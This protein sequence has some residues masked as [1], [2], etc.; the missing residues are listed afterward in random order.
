MQLHKYSVSALL[1]TAGLLL[2]GC[3]S[4]LNIQP[5]NDVAPE[6]ALTNAVDL[7]S[8]LI[9]AY[10][11]LSS[12]N[13]YGGDMLRDAELL[14]NSGD[15]L[16]QGTFTTVRD[17]YRKR[18]L[19]DN[20]QV[21]NTWL[22]AYRTINICNKVLD[23]LS[24]AS[25]TASRNRTEGEAKFIRASLYFELVR[26]FARAW[27][28]GDVNAN[29]GVPIVLKSTTAIDASSNVQRNTVAAVYTQVIQDLTDAEAKLPNTNGYYANKSAA[30]AMLSRV[31]LQKADYPN[32]ATAAN[33][34]IAS[35]LYQLAS[36]PLAAF[37]LQTFVNG[38]DT[39]ETIFSIHVTNQDGVNDL[40]TFYTSAE[41]GGRG[42]DIVIQ[43][44]H[45]ARY[46]T[47]D[48]RGGLFY[49]DENGYVRTVKF[50][51]KYGNVQVMRLAEMYLTRAEANFR[52]GTATGATPLA[53]VN[54]IRARA[55][56]GA[57][58]SAQLTTAAILNERRL[59][60]AFEGTLIH[61]IKR[62]RQSV[63]FGT[64][65][66]QWSD[67]RLVYPIPLREMNANPALLQNAGY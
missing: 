46:S 36:E 67:A 32:A 22:D 21:T 61:D 12:A 51:N 17:I 47:T 20:G 39:P 14:G 3:N 19:V 4:Q 64:T 15:V 9:G 63:V 56:L 53:D 62:S 30:A 35:G 59:E 42:S 40:N 49:E 44:Q 28:D 5:V 37:D 48:A 2:A 18:I 66:Y 31:Y 8:V 58:T 60:L 45:L 6:Q 29:L 10:D 1:L 57:L 23:N 65:T 55:G 16:W 26:S 25:A 41:Y 27:G 13:L 34:V 11:G 50:V 7:Q 43:D 52:A 54:L 38:A 24:L 33:R